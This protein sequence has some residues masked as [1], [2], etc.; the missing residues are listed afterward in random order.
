MLYRLLKK[1]YHSSSTFFSLSSKSSHSG[2]QS[3][4]LRELFAS[5]RD[6]SLPANTEWVV[7]QSDRFSESLESR[8]GVV[9]AWCIS[10]IPAYIKYGSLRRFLTTEVICTKSRNH[11]LWLQHRLE[12]LHSFLKCRNQLVLNSQAS[13][14]ILPTVALRKMINRDRVIL[15]WIQLDWILRFELSFLISSI[16]WHDY[17]S[18]SWEMQHAGEMESCWICLRL[19]GSH[20]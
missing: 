7:N 2:R 20:P 16:F 6:E 11:I 8:T 3:S 19:L 13:W 18:I 17:S 12:A 14:M 9:T 10:R 1:V 15:R 5:A 4:T